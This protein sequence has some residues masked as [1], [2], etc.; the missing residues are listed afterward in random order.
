MTKRLRK[1]RT[2]RLFMFKY[3][4][5]F[6]ALLFTVLV[7]NAQP[8]DHPHYEKHYKSSVEVIETDE[9]KIEIIRPHSQ[10]SFTQFNAKIYNKTQDYILIK[11]HETVFESSENGYGEKRPKEATIFI[12]PGGDISRQFKA[13][14]SI[15][16]KVDEINVSFGGFSRA[17]VNGKPAGVGEF[18]MKPEKNSVM[19]GPFA[20]TLKGWKYNSKEIT[21]NFKIRYRGEG[22]GVVNES[23]V[24]VRKEDD[25]TLPNTEANTEAMLL[26][27]MKARTVTLVRRF[28]KGEIG[29]GESVYVVMSD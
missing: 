26:S 11:R 2:K 22:L 12:E 14:G 19:M 21:A 3:I 17:P 18:K 8:K 6:A 16:F 10:E 29:K 20:V 15:G 5:L 9:V 24:Y 1:R 4:T 7:A 28:N 23:K 27:P 25:S 13:E